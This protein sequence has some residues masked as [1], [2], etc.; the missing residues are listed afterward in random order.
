MK[1]FAFSMQR[2]LNFRKTLY[3][4]ERNMLAQL[5]VERATLQDR[6]D[7]TE[8]QFLSRDVAFREKAATGGVRV[9]EVNQLNFHRESADS[10][11]DE[12]EGMIARKDIEIE[13]QLQ[14]VIE[15]DK[16]VK[17]LEKLREKQWE[18]YSAEAA[19]EEQDRILEMVSGKFAQ[20]QREQ[21]EEDEAKIK[22]AHGL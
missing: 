13:R 9:E 2:I 18:E 8:Q 10:L 14:I 6:R 4:K 1:R 20:Q 7:S 17:S 21:A 5:R 15:L 22:R 16:E 3:E 11:I 12:L 19:R